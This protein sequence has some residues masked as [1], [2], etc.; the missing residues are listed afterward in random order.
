[1]TD[2]HNNHHHKQ[3]RDLLGSLS[4]Y[5]N[6]DLEDALCKEI[7]SHMEGCENCRIVVN[8]LAKTI[9]LYREAAPSD[10]LPKDVKQRLYK[11]L[12]LAPLLEDDVAPQD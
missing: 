11:S 2:Q 9:E 10:A 8:T 1:M 12:N 6:G 7:E 4:D 5:V 3:C